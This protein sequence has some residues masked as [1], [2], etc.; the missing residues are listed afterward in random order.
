MGILD[1]DAYVVY[2][3][4]LS[5]MVTNP[6]EEHVHRVRSSRATA[7]LGSFSRYYEHLPTQFSVNI[8]RGNLSYHFCSSGDAWRELPDLLVG[9]SFAP[10]SSPSPLCFRPRAL[11]RRF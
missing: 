6:R 5:Y 2:S 8:Y 3:L 1:C 4:N 7:W 10:A 11:R 9:F